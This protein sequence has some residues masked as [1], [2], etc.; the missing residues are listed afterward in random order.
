MIKLDK[1]AETIEA[2]VGDE[3][4]RTANRRSHPLR[5]FA[6]RLALPVSY[7]LSTLKEFG[8]VRRRL[9]TRILLLESFFA[10]DLPCDRRMVASVD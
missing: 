9:G 6:P 1:M 5:H 8:N 3:A 10:Y 2:D 7:I 4:N